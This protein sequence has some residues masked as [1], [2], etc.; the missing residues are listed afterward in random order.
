MK[1]VTQF[2]VTIT[3]SQGKYLNKL[4]HIPMTKDVFLILYLT[5]TDP[6]IIISVVYIHD[7]SA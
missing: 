7:T 4:T 3:Y 2:P 1:N 6:D 5:C